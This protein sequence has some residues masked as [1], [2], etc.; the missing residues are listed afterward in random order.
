MLVLP[1]VASAYD[2]K[3][4]GIYY[5]FD[6]QKK[7]A[8]VT[9]KGEWDHD[10]YDAV[11]IPKVVKYEGGEYAV[12][13]IGTKAFKSCYS[14]VS[15]EIP[16]S[17][18][19]I[20]KSAFNGTG[21]T[22]I[23]IPNSVKE[24]G[25]GAFSSC[26]SLTSIKIPNSVTVMSDGLLSGCYALT[27]VTI[28]KSVKDIKDNVF[29]ECTHLTSVN[30]PEGVETIG[31]NAFYGCSRLSSVTLPKTLKKIGFSA[32]FMD[33]KL[34]T[35]YC[36]AENVPEADLYI[37]D[38]VPATIYVP[39]ASV[40]KYKSTEPWSWK[41]I[42]PLADNTTAVSVVSSNCSIVASDGV[43]TVAGEADG[44]GITV[45]SVGGQLLGKAVVKNGVAEVDT[46]LQSGS[47]VFVKVG[48]KSVKV[49]L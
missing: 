34:K 27:D 5:N 29:R 41:T 17:V 6:K 15:V 22:S 18:T 35:I 36:Y 49:V 16:N 8:E 19:V 28:G 7:T 11:K 3:V 2:A 42:K 23:T 43:V 32:F 1:M 30:I 48:Q 33:E 47:V 31:G 46:K 21:I 39:A 44:M 45:Y 9:Y 14:L 26:E 24:I 10:Y 13:K 37:F 25:E 12:T 20:E 40:A 4:D 38:G